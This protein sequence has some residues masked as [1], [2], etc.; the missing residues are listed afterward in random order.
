MMTAEHRSQPLMR[1][2]VYVTREQHDSIF[3]YSRVLDIS[4]AELTRRLLAK[5]L[6]S[7]AKLVTQAAQTIIA[8]PASRAVLGD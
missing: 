6:P 3:A 2:N 1:I 5:G 8:G 4:A 7:I